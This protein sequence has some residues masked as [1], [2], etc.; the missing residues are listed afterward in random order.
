MRKYLKKLCFLAT[1]AY[2]VGFGC[3][4]T[5]VAVKQPTIIRIEEAHKTV[6]IDP[7]LKES[8]PEYVVLDIGAIEPDQLI[9][10]A[11]KMMVYNA[12]GVQIYIL[13]IDS[14]GGFVGAGRAFARFIEGIPQRTV[15]LV[16]GK[17]ASMALYV[18]QSCDWRV[19]VEDGQL[20]AHEPHMLM[21]QGAAITRWALENERKELEKDAIEM[22]LHIT[23]RSKMEPEFY[24]A[25][26]ASSPT[27][28]FSMTAEEALDL[29]FLDAIVP[30]D[31]V[32][33][34]TTLIEIVPDSP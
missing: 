10:T 17:A 23:R 7:S 9:D 3:C 13:K 19:A 11:T 8:V 18:L 28:A 24:E 14:S 16:T 29:G 32:P 2:F 26:L 31:T 6:S 22:A 27:A 15:C 30:A 1:L 4:C 20:V 25:A 12:L 21:M 33:E 5:T 34:T